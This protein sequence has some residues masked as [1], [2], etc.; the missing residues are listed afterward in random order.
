MLNFIVNPKAGG[1]SG[2][3]ITKAVKTIKEY[4]DGKKIEYKIYYTTKKG[5]AT[6]ITEELTSKKVDN[7]IAVGG[8]GTLH[9]VINGFKDFSNTALGIIPC[10]TGNDFASSLKI[11]FNV[12]DAVNLILEGLPKYTDFMQMPT[13]RGLNVIGMGL[14][15]EVLKKYERLK[16]KTKFGYYWCL[17]KT[18]MNFGYTK[19]TTIINGE[20]T[21]YDAF[22]ACIA[23]GNQYGGGIKVCPIADPTD[24]ELNFL[25][26][27]KIKKS[28]ILGALIKLL[29]GKI[30]TLPQTETKK[31]K[32][33]KIECDTPYTVNVDGEL[34]ENIPFEINIVSNQL[35]VYRK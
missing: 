22:V 20:K 12:I 18:L 21:N 7:V 28:K 5:D 31:V 13:I 9:E 34:Y 11:P 24:K 26:V 8:D 2:K 6:T 27:D 33:I 30:L 19:F 1:K 16:K 25:T 35:M 4:L 14:D 3:K 17:I 23:N 10:G 32:S 29:K 15:V